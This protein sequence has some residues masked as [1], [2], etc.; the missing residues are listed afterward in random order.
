MKNIALANPFSGLNVPGS[1]VDKTTLGTFIS[2]LLPYVYS[3]AGLAL[4]V[5][6][7][8]GGIGLMLSRGDPK[9]IEMAKAKITTALIGFIII[10]LAYAI[11]KLVGLVLGIVT[12]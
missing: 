2:G 6:L 7:S 3:F 10:I 4:L 12:I 1:A 11:S 8:L 9:A 5:Y